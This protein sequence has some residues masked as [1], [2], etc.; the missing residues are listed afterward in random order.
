MLQKSYFSS[1]DEQLAVGFYAYA[2]D[3]DLFQSFF[4]F[5]SMDFPTFSRVQP[6]RTVIRRVPIFDFHRKN[7]EKIWERAILKCGPN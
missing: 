4:H 5:F 6:V 1:V 3:C 7:T 2:T